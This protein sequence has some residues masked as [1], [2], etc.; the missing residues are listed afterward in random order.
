LSSAILS[1]RGRKAARPHE[2]GD[3]DSRQR[4]KNARPAAAALGPLGS[5]Y[6][7]EAIPA[8]PPDQ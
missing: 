3:P 1:P 8:E 5:E 7:A 4:E 2:P 6:G